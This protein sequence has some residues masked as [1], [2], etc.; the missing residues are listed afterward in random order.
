[1]S[2]LF[3]IINHINENGTLPRSIDS[4]LQYKDYKEDATKDITYDFFTAEDETIPIEKPIDR[5][6]QT[7][8]EKLEPQF[9]DYKKLNY[10]EITPLVR[11]Y[12][13]PSVKIIGLVEELKEKYGIV[14]EN[15]CGILYRGN[16]KAIETTPPSYK[17]IVEK[18]SRLK[19]INPMLRFFVQTDEK[20]FLDEFL[21]HFP[22]SIYLNETHRISRQKS[23]VQLLL[24]K[25]QVYN[26]TLYYVAALHILASC[27]HLIMTSGNGELWVC[28]YRGNADRV[29]QYLHE[30]EYI[31]GVKNNAYNPNKKYFWL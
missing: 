14:P 18:A 5:K 3:D 28:L 23:S 31:W 27:K 19:K 24:P 8:D 22:N 25:K 1:M 4:S 16:D 11:R 17:E 15:M 20:E 30:N 2:R 26:G 10:R 13:S 12:F 29:H 7:T 21:R 9:S 6:L